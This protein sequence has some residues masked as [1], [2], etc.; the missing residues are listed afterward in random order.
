MTFIITD[1]FH[2]KIDTYLFYHPLYNYGIKIYLFIIVFPPFPIHFRK[3]SFNLTVSS[4]I[5]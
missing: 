1:S 3:K 2:N 4:F 5:F